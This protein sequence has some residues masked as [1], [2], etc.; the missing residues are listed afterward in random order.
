MCACTACHVTRF[1]LQHK[2]IPSGV[3]YTSARFPSQIGWREGI[4]LNRTLL[5]KAQLCEL[6]Y[7]CEPGCTLQGSK[8]NTLRASSSTRIVLFSC[9]RATAHE[10]PLKGNNGIERCRI[11]SQGVTGA[12]TSS[13]GTALGPRVPALLSMPLFPTWRV[14]AQK[15][16]QEFYLS[17]LT[18]PMYLC[19]Q[20]FSSMSICSACPHSETFHH[21]P[22]PIKLQEPAALAYPSCDSSI[23][24]PIHPVSLTT[25]SITLTTNWLWWLSQLITPVL[26]FDW[27]FLKILTNKLLA[28]L[29]AWQTVIH[30]QL[31]TLAQPVL[32]Y[33]P[34][35]LDCSTCI[36]SVIPL[37]RPYTLSTNQQFY[38]LYPSLRKIALPISFQLFSPKHP[39]GSIQRP[40]AAIDS[41]I[42]FVAATTWELYLLITASIPPHS[43]DNLIKTTLLDC[44]RL[45]GL[46]LSRP[47]IHR[48]SSSAGY[49]KTPRL[50]VQFTPRYSSR[51]IDLLKQ[52]ISGV[53][54]ELFLHLPS[55]NHSLSPKVHI[56]ILLR[57]TNP[58][59]FSFFLSHRSYYYYYIYGIPCS[60]HFHFSSTSSFINITILPLFNFPIIIFPFHSILVSL[61]S[62]ISLTLPV[63]LCCVACL[64]ALAVYGG[65]LR[66]AAVESCWSTLRHS[67][68]HVHCTPPRHP[69]LFLSSDI[70][71]HQSPFLISF[72]TCQPVYPTQYS[73]FKPSVQWVNVEGR[74]PPPLTSWRK[75]ADRWEVVVLIK[76]PNGW[77]CS[78]GSL[79]PD[80]ATS[81]LSCAEASSSHVNGSLRVYVLY[82]QPAKRQPLLK[83][84]TRSIPT[85]LT[86]HHSITCPA[87]LVSSSS[88]SLSSHSLLRSFL[89]CVLDRSRFFDIHTPSA[90]PPPL[91]PPPTTSSLLTVWLQSLTVHL[92]FYRLVLS[93]SPLLVSLSFVAYIHYSRPFFIFSSSFSQAVSLLAPGS[94]PVHRLFD[95]SYNKIKNHWSSRPHN[96]THSRNCF[97]SSHVRSAALH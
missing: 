6:G 55:S 78:C 67:A 72:N 8:H 22:R 60:V 12:L 20:K 49:F 36:C 41:L 73:S 33:K 84:F 94:H 54:C 9:W 66:G 47:S 2:F 16:N 50:F 92:F 82:G 89:P 26:L 17:A 87:P 70:I 1:Q 69:S 18:P 62:F 97:K 46:V 30:S 86:S 31:W 3:S 65:W 27:I 56:A 59:S 68:Y 13:Y 42:L 39:N 88:T 28:L 61:A 53:P 57:N 93:S 32:T 40:R 63:S 51:G 81:N 80:R 96:T 21:F 45:T 77:L 10:K 19:C 58:S 95:R 38:S 4:N 5:T 23:T 43:L 7:Q 11:G 52:P 29:T 48:D 79:L 14:E 74:E 64:L 24:K 37:H 44:C 35:V 76:Q 75:S 15:G 85:V 90:P 71:N 25:H 34:T 83:Y 91:P